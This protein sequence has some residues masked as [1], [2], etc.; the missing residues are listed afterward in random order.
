[1]YLL[2]RGG[3]GHLTTAVP[4]PFQHPHQHP[5]AAVAKRLQGRQVHDDEGPAGRHSSDQMRCGARGHGQ[6]KLPAQNNDGLTADITDADMYVRHKPSLTIGPPGTFEFR[7]PGS[8]DS[9]R[10]WSEGSFAESQKEM[11]RN[12]STAFAVSEYDQSPRSGAT[13]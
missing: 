6:V 8:A 2:L 10:K 13:N 7:L 3:Q 9:G 12:I 1:M 4:R 5:Q 11:L